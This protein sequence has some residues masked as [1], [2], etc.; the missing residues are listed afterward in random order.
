M[1]LLEKINFAAGL[2]ALEYNKTTYIADSHFGIEA[3]LKTKGVNSKKDHENLK[4]LKE[5]SN[6]FDSKKLIVVGD[7]KHGINGY[8]KGEKN[9]ILEYLNELNYTEIIVSKGNHDSEIEELLEIEQ[10][11]KIMKPEGFTHDKIG[12]FHGHATPSKE[13]LETKLVFLGHNHPVVKEETGKIPCWVHGKRKNNNY[14]LLFPAFSSLAQGFPINSI[15]KT[16]DLMGPFFKKEE[17]SYEEIK[18]N[19]INGIA[20]GFL[21]NIPKTKPKK[22]KEQDY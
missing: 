14:F 8:E 17:V 7:F 12:V 6:E 16:S 4:K 1:N 21:K 13:V 22:P 5:F 11:L 15:E 3:F 19:T 10:R 20:L 18:V 9:I 2:P